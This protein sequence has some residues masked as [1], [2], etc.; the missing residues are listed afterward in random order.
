MEKPLISVLLSAYNAGA[1]V[2]RAIHS[3]LRQSVTR[4]EVVAIDDGSTD[5]TF[6]VLQDLAQKDHRV[7]VFRHPNMGLTRSLNQGLWL[8]RAPLVARIDADD[9]CLTG[10]LQKQ[11]DFLQAHP[12]YGMVG[13]QVLLNTDTGLKVLALPVT[14]REIL[15]AL[16]RDNP[17][18]HPSV[19]F[20]RQLVLDLGGYDESFRYAQDYDLWFRLLRRAKAYNLPELV[21]LRRIH[22]NMLGEAHGQAQLAC[23]I[24]VRIKNLAISPNPLVSLEAIVRRAVKLPVYFPVVRQFYRKH[25]KKNK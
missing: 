8:C 2:A 21:V 15:N 3:C 24:R 12:D 23:S 9:E 22:S 4:I 13:G 25:I 6:D 14:H 10:R 7:R 20:R 17:I 19:M 18:V 5:N 11:M 16:P 1:T